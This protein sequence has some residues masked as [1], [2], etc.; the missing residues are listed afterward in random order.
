MVEF[1]LCKTIKVNLSRMRSPIQISSPFLLFSAVVSAIACGA[2]LLAKLPGISLTIIFTVL[3][4][5]LPAIWFTM[6]KPPVIANTLKGKDKTNSLALGFIMSATVLGSVSG[7]L[8]WV[9]YFETGSLVRQV[10]IAASPLLGWILAL[11]GYFLVTRG[12]ILIANEERQRGFLLGALVFSTAGILFF[13]WL[14]AQ[15]FSFTIDDAYITFRYSKPNP[16]S[17][18]SANLSPSTKKIAGG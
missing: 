15:I 11:T 18:R 8:S 3:F 5:H 10:L 17:R 9:L 16:S 2:A 1:L 7:L 12:H 14:T 4:L 13:Y 6:R